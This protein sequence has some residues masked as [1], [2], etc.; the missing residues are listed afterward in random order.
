MG[1]RPPRGLTKQAIA[2]SDVP[3][4]LRKAAQKEVPDVELS[5]AWKNLDSTG[6]LHS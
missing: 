4:D 6:K 3:E 5:E 2:I 1:S